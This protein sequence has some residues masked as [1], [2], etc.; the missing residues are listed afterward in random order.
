M[1]KVTTEIVIGHHEHSKIIAELIR[2]A[3]RQILLVCPWL[4][5]DA[6]NQ[7]WSIV[8]DALK[9]GVQIFLLWGIN[10]DEQLDQKIRNILVDL[11]Q[12]YPTL[13]FVSQRS[14]R[15]HAKLVVQDDRN[16]LATSLNFLS[17][18][19]PDTMEVGILIS[20]R[21]KQHPAHH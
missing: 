1:Q 19:N 2:N 18:S 8:Q 9:R 12:R 4:S 21:D 17:P 14:S 3:A 11:R 5:Y 15:T 20:A 6:V 10:P 7:L 13:F 16:A